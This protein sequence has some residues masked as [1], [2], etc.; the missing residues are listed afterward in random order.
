MKKRW[1]AMRLKSSVFA[2]APTW[3]QGSRRLE[4]GIPGER[5]ILKE[6]EI[7]IEAGDLPDH[8]R[9]WA[10]GQES[11]LESKLGVW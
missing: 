6:K 4:Q 7:E 1:F 9:G 8:S 10:C 3:L 2:N 5:L 11:K